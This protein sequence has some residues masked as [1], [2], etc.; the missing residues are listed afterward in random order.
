[1][2]HETYEVV[3]LTPRHLAKQDLGPILKLF[4]AKGEKQDTISRLTGKLFLDLDDL[5]KS[6]QVGTGD[7]VLRAYFQ[8]LDR[9]LP[10]LPLFL[11]R[12]PEAGQLLLYTSF[13]VDHEPDGDHLRFD[14]P[15]LERFALNKVR[16]IHEFCQ[17]QK[18]D[19]RPA[20]RA[21]CKELNLEVFE[22]LESGKPQ[23]PFEPERITSEFLIHFFEHG[24]HFHTIDSSD[25]PVLFA[26]VDD[27]ERAYYAQTSLELKLFRSTSF[28]VIHLE[29]TVF[30]E[31]DNPLTMSFLY[32]VEQAKHRQE[33]AAYAEMAYLT[34]NFLFKNE[35]ELFYGFS[36]AVELPEELRAR[37][38]RLMQQAQ[39]LLRA[40]PKEARDFG[41]AVEE[42]FAKG[43]E[44]AKE[45]PREEE[46]KPKPA[47]HKPALPARSLAE[48]IE[49]EPAPVSPK[50]G[51]G[52]LEQGELPISSPRHGAREG[53]GAEQ[54]P[55]PAPVQEAKPAPATVERE[56]P[57]AA[58]EPEPAQAYEPS[59]S[60]A[61]I[62]D[63]YDLETPEAEERAADDE[64]QADPEAEPKPYVRVIENP[65][66]PNIL[67]E[68][69]QRI[70]RA[71]SKPV[72]RPDK[73][74]TDELTVKPAPRRVALRDEDQLE[75]L[76]RRLLI[77]Q[78][79]LETCERENLRLQ[80]ELK[81]ARDEVEK[82]QRENLDMES[83]WW[84][85]WK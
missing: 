21:F 70:T 15:Q 81:T 63:E 41:Q 34:T 18:L 56:A 61:E 53:Q 2:T 13:L 75:R 3:R 40:I 1:M 57:R 52:R 43:G 35:G 10:H 7:P 79:K 80:A 6:G 55:K 12:S 54:K 84:K 42:L 26:L 9:E 47:P 28:P 62:L 49:E 32:N 27:P 33:L 16:A 5:L 51:K 17:E 64:S 67:P 82:L 50:K 68:N 65:I 14:K 72:R 66:P 60:R 44:E 83:R 24:Y 74:I 85:F 11:A 48:L 76:S 22:E 78:S 8:A 20:I 31:P 77:T 23:Y 58:R 46:P 30:D 37:I 69:I 59:A 45:P 25:E 39:G 71:L 38:P 36:R 4:P 19:A 73:A 29:F